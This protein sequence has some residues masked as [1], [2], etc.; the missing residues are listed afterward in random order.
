[1]P[2]IATNPKPRVIL[3]LMVCSPAPKLQYSWLLAAIAMHQ[4]PLDSLGLHT[5]QELVAQ[6]FG[7]D[8]DSGARITSLDDYKIFL[9]HFQAAGF[10]E[11][12]T[13]RSYVGGKQEAFTREA[14]WKERGLTL[15]TYVILHNP[16]SFV[17]CQMFVEGPVT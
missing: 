11:I 16:T 8:P 15:A 14:G 6:T 2:L 3:G 17:S 5:N 10:T 4:K 7:P 1:M 12:D 13:A 9:D